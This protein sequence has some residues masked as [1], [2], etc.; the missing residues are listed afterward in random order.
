[1]IRMTKLLLSSIGA[2]SIMSAAPSAIAATGLVNL[3]TDEVGM[4][5]ISHQAL[6][7][8]GADLS[9]L[10]IRRLALSVDGQPVAFY[11]KGQDRQHGRRNLFGLGGYIEFYAEGSN[12]L[13]TGEQA[14]TLS[15]IRPRE[16]EDLQVDIQPDRVKFDQ[17][18]QADA[19]YEHT[20]VVEE[21]NFYD[22]IAPE[23][24]IDPWHF[25]QT[26][27]LQ[28]NTPTYRFELDN[29]AGNGQA[30]VQVEMYGLLDF[31]IEGNDHAY[32]AEINGRVIGEQQFDGATVSVLEADN[33][34]VQNG[35]NT[36]KYNYLPVAG[37]AFDRIA[38]NKVLVT[39]PRATVA[40]NGYLQ[41]VM[42]AGQ[43]QVSGAGTNANVFR[44]EGE[45]IFRIINKQGLNGNTAFNASKAGEYIVV[46]DDAFK[47][48]K[49][50]A[51]IIDEQD[52]TSGDA[53]YLV[54]AHKSLMGSALDELVQIREAQY[55]VKVV[56]V[57]QIYAQFGNHLP[58]ADAIQ[59]YI[60]FAKDNL[61]TKMVL[62]V[63]STHYDYRNYRTDAVSLVPTQYVAT[64]AGIVTV[65]QTPS[66]AAFGDTD[67]N[68]VPDMAIGR[69][70]ARTESEL[71]NVVEKIRDFKAR[72]GYAGR[73]LI[74]ADKDD[75]G[76][77]ISFSEDAEDLIAAMPEDWA[78]S[79]RSDYR[80]YPDVDGAQN[81]K[82][83]LKAAISAGVSVV[84][85]IGHSS[86][87]VW[88]YAT[89]PLLL[90]SEVPTLDNLDKPAVIAQWGCWNTYFVDP[91]GNSMAD[92]F[93]L[94]GQTGAVA[95]LGASTLTSAGEERSFG[96]ELNKHLYTRGL[97]I[98]EAIIRAKQALAQNE[99]APAIQLGYQLM[100][101]P[102]EVINF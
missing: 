100:G 25:G 60:K 93:L 90:A 24:N 4:H 40:S 69:I 95:V 16:R 5:R 64:P 22:T 85:Y 18:L 88:S 14:F 20:E 32:S 84:S 77:G 86:Q 83:K 68:G 101:D 10:N 36:V 43:V 11:V 81:A 30:K 33:V 78:G 72:E 50:I 49:R 59:S 66:D 9:G 19:V 28:P 44:K 38:L 52:I 97:P 92:L 15:A 12:S 61:D 87:Q 65:T 102:A 42:Q 51:P 75:I 89:P 57:E 71:A 76:T 37:V 29:V 7:A 54:I 46:A 80:A 34:S 74:A 8:Q 26:I 2:L 3:I 62:I 56:D 39:Y 48:V 23:G 13:Y 6:V 45:D 53:Q 1:M 35:V 98:G 41:G 91:R 82:D 96:I 63:G 99:D 47:Q 94:A 31:A 17:T 58:S 27:S 21:N 79:I 67:N 55:S 73:V 70:Q